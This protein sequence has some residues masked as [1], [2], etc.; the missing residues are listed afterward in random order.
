MAVSPCQL[1]RVWASGPDR[2]KRY[3]ESSYLSVRGVAP[4]AKKAGTSARRPAEIKAEKAKGPGLEQRINA[5][6]QTRGNEFTSVQELVS[7]LKVAAQV[8]NLTLGNM[9]KAERIEKN[10]NGLVRLARK[11]A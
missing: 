6:L 7:Q 11:A 9:R 2:V 5:Y 8:L 3:D 1:T 10:P 4:K